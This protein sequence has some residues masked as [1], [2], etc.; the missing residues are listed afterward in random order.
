MKNPC[1]FP[2]TRPEGDR[3]RRIFRVQLF[4]FIVQTAPY[5]K[6]DEICECVQETES[7]NLSFRRISNEFELNAEQCQ[8][9]KE[10]VFLTWKLVDFMT[11]NNTE[12]DLGEGFADSDDIYGSMK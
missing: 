9:K 4:V 10:N 2:V 8:N 6:A 12:I 11:E 7:K 5:S 3:V 1:F